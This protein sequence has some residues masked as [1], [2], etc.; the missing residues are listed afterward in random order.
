M[1][2]YVLIPYLALPC[3]GSGPQAASRIP[4]QVL[5]TK[6]R[7][8]PDAAVDG[9]L[10]DR[11]DHPPADYRA[12]AESQLRNRL[13]QV[14]KQLCSLDITAVDDDTITLGIPCAEVIDRP[15]PVAQMCQ[16]AEWRHLTLI[17]EISIASDN[18]L[19]LVVT[20]MLLASPINL[21]NW[22]FLVRGLLYDDTT[23]LRRWY[24]SGNDCFFAQIVAFAAI[25]MS[26]P[27]I[28][29]PLS[30]PSSRGMQL[31]RKLGVAIINGL[32][33]TSW[34]AERRLKRA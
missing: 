21:V 23:I 6:N 2:K 4:R 9:V 24:Q 18:F 15:L 29:L 22:L 20:F 16:R 31:A 12:D 33:I 5:L 14:I 1:I 8:I 28:R 10:I 17:E 27:R 13:A 30:E 11:I 34:I 7:D 3:L 19:K 26:N 25:L 32:I